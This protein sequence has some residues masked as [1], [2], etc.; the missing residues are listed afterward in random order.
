MIKNL[1]FFAIIILSVIVGYMYFFGEG[2]DKEKA[3]NVV[4]ETKELG[5]SVGDFLKRQKDRYDNGEFDRLLKRIDN[6]IDSVRN[7][8]TPTTIAETKELK[9]LET[10]LRQVDA[11]KLSVENRERLKQILRDLDTEIEKTE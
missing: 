10:E 7:K 9:E 2:E 1:V 8:D 11:D 5:K 4:N 6:I 3:H